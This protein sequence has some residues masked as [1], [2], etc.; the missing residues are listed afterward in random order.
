MNEKLR[1][2]AQKTGLNFEEVTGLFE[3]NFKT[4]KETIEAPEEVI[5]ERAYERTR[6]SLKLKTRQGIENVSL[7]VLGST[8]I[9]WAKKSRDKIKRVISSKGKEEAINLGM[10]DDEG[11]YLY[12]DAKRAG[13]VIP[14][15][16]FKAIFYCVTNVNGKIIPVDLEIRLPEIAN[17]IIIGHEIVVRAQKITKWSTEN[18][19][20]YQLYGNDAKVL[21]KAKPEEI[22]TISELF[23]KD[24]LTIDYSKEGSFD[25]LIKI[26]DNKNSRVL[27]KNFLVQN[28]RGDVGDD[29]KYEITLDT[30]DF[31]TISQIKV[32][33]QTLNG[34]RIVENYSINI[35]CEISGY[36][37]E[38]KSIAANS[39]LY[40]LSPEFV[41]KNEEVA[42]PTKVT[43]EW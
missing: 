28:V 31:D 38:T 36:N 20:Y 35:L 41:K 30:P 34:Q 5:K 1:A 2:L 13:K 18:K 23:C 37:A 19:M 43:G 24:V 17:K 7:I 22:S 33:A 16:D 42:E 6:S 25:E 14:T 4:L 3:E 39:I 27:L 8:S 29:K 15:Q 32:Y 12:T 26:K 9:D 40:W 21:E 10:I 11:N